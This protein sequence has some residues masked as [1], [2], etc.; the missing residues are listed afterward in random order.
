M[1]VTF[2]NSQRNLA[3]AARNVRTRLGLAA[4]SLE[5]SYDERTEYIR[6]L[7]AEILRYP[8][9][10]VDAHLSW[11][12]TVAGKSYEKLAEISLPDEVAEIVAQTAA[13]SVPVLGDFTN[14]LLLILALGV[15]VWFGVRAMRK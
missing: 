13:N 14:K 8:Q 7:A 10:F 12:H 2:E 15:A 5:W 11:A 4:S 9:S 6:Q 3:T 1:A